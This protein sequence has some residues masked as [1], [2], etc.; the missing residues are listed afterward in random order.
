MHF[1]GRSGAKSTISKKANYHTE[2]IIDLQS[3][4][5]L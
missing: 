4:Q 3:A 2:A 1:T 5:G